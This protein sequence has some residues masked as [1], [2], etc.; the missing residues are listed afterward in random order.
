MRRLTLATCKHMAKAACRA[1]SNPLDQGRYVFLKDISFGSRAIAKDF[2]AGTDCRPRSEVIDTGGES[3]ASETPSSLTALCVWEFGRP[4]ASDCSVETL[5]AL[6]PI[7][8]L[9]AFLSCSLRERERMALWCVSSL[10][11]VAKRRGEGSPQDAVSGNG[12]V[13]V[14]L[15]AVVQS[16]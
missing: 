1:H 4:S 11:T 13:A 12:K 16:K 7:L 15:I 3:G 14:I 5:K 10:C 6:E 8:E 9:A 2:A